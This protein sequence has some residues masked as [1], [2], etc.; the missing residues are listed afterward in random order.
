MEYEWVIETDNYIRFNDSS[1]G[2]DDYTPFAQESHKFVHEYIYVGDV[3]GISS[4]QGDIISPFFVTG[5]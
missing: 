1:K 5:L 3:I 2:R 4:R